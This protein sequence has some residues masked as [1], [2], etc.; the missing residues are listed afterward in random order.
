MDRVVAKYRSFQEAERAEREAAWALTAD[1]RM[2][3]AKELR[4]RVY[5]RDAID[6]R[7]SVR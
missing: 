6:V 1:E 4:D 3:I 5:G 2:R 7:A